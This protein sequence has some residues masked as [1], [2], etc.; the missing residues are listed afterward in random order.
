MKSEDIKKYNWKNIWA[1]DWNLLDVSDWGEHYLG[2]LK[3]GK[4]P[5]LDKVVFVIKNGKSSCWVD[6]DYLKKSCETLSKIYTNKKQIQELAGNLKHSVDKALKVMRTKFTANKET[7]NDYRKAI[8]EYYVPHVHVKY[9]IDGFSEKQ[10]KDFLP[11][12]QEA[13]VYAEPVFA[14]TLKFDSELVRQ[15]SKKEKIKSE[16]L[17]S[18]TRDE[19][20]L[21]FDTGKLPK[22]KELLERY[23]YSVS[24]LDAD[25]KLQ[26]Y[27]GNDAQKLEQSLVEIKETGDL[28]G[29]TAFPGMA[30]GR[31]LIIFDPRKSKGFK[32]GDILVT[33][34]TRP[35]YLPLMHK[36][37]A[38]VTDAGGMLSHAAITARELKKPC[39]V[40]TKF[41]TKV[42]KD[43]DKVEVDADK[44]IVR[45]VK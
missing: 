21:Y 8:R 38:F 28:R 6:E 2:S 29:Q 44:G 16:L 25:K 35:E 37:A 5:F 30:K 13:R 9:V 39:I 23:K 3:I 12:L 15:L 33:G 11:I 27:T 40:G 18:L 22:E 1:G 26:I 45:K 41:A 32:K 17:L 10:R 36:A 14:E 42:L 34:M 43:G 4:R 20:N 7:Y 19:L 24:V 31:V